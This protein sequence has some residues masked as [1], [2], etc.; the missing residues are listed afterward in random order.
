MKFLFAMGLVVLNV[1]FVLGQPDAGSIN[2]AY[3]VG[4]IAGRALIGPLIVSSLFCLS[5]RHRYNYGRLLTGFVVVSTLSLVGEASVG[6]RAPRWQEV[7]VREGGFT[8]EVP[9][10]PVTTLNVEN[11]QA[12]DAPRLSTC[13]YLTR[14]PYREYSVTWLATP[15]V[16]MD[17]TDENLNRLIDL[18]TTEGH[19]W[20]F[21][22]TG[23]KPLELE[24]GL[25]GQYRGR[26]LTVE[27]G[28]SEGALRLFVVHDRFYVLVGID[29]PANHARI[30]RFFQSFQL[31]A[32]QP[33]Q[34]LT[35]ALIPDDAMPAGPSYT[36]EQARALAQSD[37]AL[38]RSRRPDEAW[39]YLPDRV[40]ERVTPAEHAAFWR[41][42]ASAAQ[43]DDARIG[44]IER[45]TVP[46]EVM[47]EVRSGSGRR[48][49]TK[50]VMLNVYS[51]GRGL[52]LIPAELDM[53]RSVE[54][55]NAG[56]TTT[57]PGR[58]G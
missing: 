53:T 42:Q 49:A 34:A 3:L 2:R 56:S 57:A 4:E 58:P 36:D 45:G 39:R 28:L 38:L 14:L 23:R 10:V 54:T 6:Y 20:N 24:R 15:G 47:L 44:P 18:I 32:R 5:R 37:L 40:R 50:R 35:A 25:A 52:S 29:L 21:E 17:A 9:G 7:T 11:E 26:E 41:R 13:G 19:R 48:P 16:A 22:V 55:E 51:G 1:L 30:D 43:L 46:G 31:L 33:R 8:V 27:S 12:K